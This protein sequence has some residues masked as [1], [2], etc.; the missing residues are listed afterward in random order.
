MAMNK[1]KRKLFKKG[2]NHAGGLK[3]MNPSK[4]NITQKLLCSL[5]RSYYQRYGG[6]NK[7]ENNP[8]ITQITQI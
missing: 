8:Q 6:V 4:Y 3:I 1:I 7:E 5:R 2:W